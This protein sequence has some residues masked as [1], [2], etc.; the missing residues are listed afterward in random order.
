MKIDPKAQAL[1]DSSRRSVPRLFNA[2]TQSMH[3][4]GVVGLDIRA[5]DVAGA[6][7]ESK[8][9]LTLYLNSPG[10]DFFDGKAIFSALSRYASRNKVTAIVDGVA[11]SAASLIAM[12][13]TRIEMS[14][15]A[16]MMIH[17]VHGGAAGRAQDLEATAALIRAE[18]GQL[19]AIYASRTGKPVEE[20]SS[21]LA[22]GDTW[23]TAE[24]AVSQKFADGIAGQEP[25]PKKKSPRNDAEIT[26]RITALRVQTLSHPVQNRTK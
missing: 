16:S 23:M 9:P 14:P 1:F 12:A 11:A 19:A 3:L 17:E 13:A 20:V 24:E 7:A 8:G 22:A 18:N 10:G 5:S 21:M 15:S 25:A 2:A 6:L 26:K 4:Y